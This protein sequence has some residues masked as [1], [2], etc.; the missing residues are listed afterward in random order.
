[1]RRLTPY[2]YLKW[3]EH[4]GESGFV[5]WPLRAALAKHSFDF[6]CAN[7]GKNSPQ[8]KMENY[9]FPKPPDKRTP[10]QKMADAEA[11]LIGA[12]RG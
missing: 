3:V 8:P 7:T 4:F 11:A 2:S 6:A 1:M 12:A 9:M 5:P 10:E